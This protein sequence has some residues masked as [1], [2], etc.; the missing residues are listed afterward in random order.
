M[1]YDSISRFALQKYGPSP[2]SALAALQIV[3]TI[4]Y[5]TG[6]T[7]IYMHACICAS[8]FVDL[9]ANDA[10]AMGVDLYMHVL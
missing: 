6:S 2:A 8:R 10:A 1:N 9:R 5:G 3:C 4:E 7:Y